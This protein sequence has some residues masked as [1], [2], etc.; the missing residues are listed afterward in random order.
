[1][2]HNQS[3]I[4]MESLWRTF[5][6]FLVLLLLL[7]A[8]WQTVPAQAESSCPAGMHCRYIPF[9]ASHP[10]SDDLKLSH[11]E[12]TQAVQDSQNSVPLVAGRPTI[13]R[14][15]AT[16]GVEFQEIS[17]VQ[18]QVNASRDGAALN[19][20]PT[21]FQTSIPLFNNRANYSSTINLQLPPTWLSGTVDMSISLDPENRIA[22]LD[23]G[24][25]KLV[26][27]L[28]FQPVPPLNIVVVPIQYTHTPNGLTY[29]APVDETISDW[30]LRVFPVS[31]VNVSWHAPYSF[32]GN[33]RFASDWNTL[34]Y[35][36]TSL[37][38][39]EGAPSSTVYYGL[40]P[41]GEGSS[42]WFTGGIAG[43]GWI[44]SR[45]AVGLKTAS[46][47]S[48]IAAHEVGHNLGMWHSP[49]GTLSSVDP[50]YPYANGLI[51]QY[52][53]DVFSGTVYRPDL[54]RDLMSY[55]YPRWISDYTY[56]HLMQ[57][58]ILDGAAQQ[59]MLSAPA[60]GEAPQRS[61]LVRA[62]VGSAGAT[63]LPVYVL[64]EQQNENPPAGDYLVRLYGAD[65]GLLSEV[66]L[67]ENAI[68]LDGEQSIGLHA[69]VPLPAQPVALV[70]LVKNDVT[71][72]ERALREAVSTETRVEADLAGD[73]LVVR[74]DGARSPALLRYTSDGGQSWT[75]LG[76]DLWGGEYAAIRA[77]L[78]QPGGS[79]E[80]ILADTWN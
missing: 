30:M 2:N 49:C 54:S 46:N 31:Q 24:N 3:P 59:K 43:I 58:Q 73:G 37:K 50:D 7:C 9:V 22:E 79:F 41:I 1:M 77:S 13:L 21:A 78:P 75:T 27:R 67:Q 56:K 80:V 64:P 33:L 8:N 36:V 25:N 11:V 62:Q 70:R 63:L 35:N 17:N 71:L 44:G 4:R 76:V 15:F 23:E 74:W 42:T 52:G 18:V 34:L 60:P 32:T 65:G 45:A 12:V 66:S 5:R 29:T 57:A 51:G 14:I 6:F 39:S 47:A 26:L 48:V 61:L 19:G 55:C 16:A 38:S 53:L 10:V 28:N 20:S 72:A 69:L 68:D 40:V